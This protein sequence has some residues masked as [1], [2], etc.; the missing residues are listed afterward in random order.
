ML[1]L[2]PQICFKTEVWD[3]WGTLQAAWP[4]PIV[5]FMVAGLGNWGIEVQPGA[6]ALTTMMDSS[7]G[8]VLCE[9]APW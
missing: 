7:V 3:D 6:L 5:V 2:V 8:I 9:P 1:K 4:P